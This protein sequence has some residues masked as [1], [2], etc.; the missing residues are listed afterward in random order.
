MKGQLKE[1]VNS[2]AA[3]DYRHHPVLGRHLVPVIRGP[4]YQSDW[5][6]V[7]SQLQLS[8]IQAWP[9]DSQSSKIVADFGASQTSGGVVG[10]GL[11]FTSA[12]F[13]KN[14]SP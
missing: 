6:Q 10:S 12:I 14:E 2:T 3:R 8:W 7:R 1:A 9:S 11:K 13:T 5:L 4:D